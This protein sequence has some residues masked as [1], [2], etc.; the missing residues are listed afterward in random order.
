M[1]DFAVA[2]IAGGVEER[3]ESIHRMNDAAQ[4]T[5]G[6]P[7]ALEAK[8]IERLKTVYDPEIPV[9][10]YDLGLIYN[11]D[12]KPAADGKFDLNIDMTLTAPGC[13]VA[14]T[15]PGMVQM[16]VVNLPEL[17]DVKVE[18]VWDPP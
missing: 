7:E 10:I 5:T 9:N 11:L 14:G 17:N 2:H 13:P 15:M 3:T 16:A 8:V 1:R 18:L 6:V 12:F 4:N